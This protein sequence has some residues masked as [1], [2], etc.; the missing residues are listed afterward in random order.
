MT[1]TTAPAFHGDFEAHLTVRADTGAEID[2]F[3]TYAAANDLKFIH[4]VLDRGR[5]PQQPMITVRRSGSFEAVRVAVE[6]LA[7][8]LSGDGFP[9]VRTKI[10]AA[11]WA[12]GV[13]QSDTRSLDPRYYFEHHI[14]L[15]LPPDTDSTALTAIA[16]IHAAHLSANARRTRPDGR[17]ERFVT[18]RCRRVGDTTAA[19]RLETLLAALTDYEILSVEREFVVHDSD[20]SIDAG[21]ITEGQQP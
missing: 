1:T 8:R 2:A 13:P 20:E 3:E 16:V 11:P 14:K 19:A 15:L 10:E 12:E 9:V 4:I 6:H 5:V 17:T 21:W 7:A 18:Q